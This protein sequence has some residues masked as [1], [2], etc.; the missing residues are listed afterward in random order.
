MHVPWKHIGLGFFLGFDSRQLHRVISTRERV[1]V[2][3]YR[4]KSGVLH[5]SIRDVAIPSGEIRVLLLSRTKHAV[6][7]LQSP[8]P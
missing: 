4:T 3:V 6:R 7:L 2:A 1:V 5:A 8:L